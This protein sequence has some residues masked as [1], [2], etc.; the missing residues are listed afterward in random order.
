MSRSEWCA[1][2]WSSRAANRSFLV[3]ESRCP[4]PR[5]TP[6]IREEE[7]RYEYEVPSESL[8]TH[9]ASASHVPLATHFF[10]RHSDLYRIAAAFRSTVGIVMNH[11]HGHPRAEPTDEAFVWRSSSHAR[12]SKKGHTACLQDP[13]N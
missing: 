10:S 4:Q 6:N 1:E 11:G 2:A 9:F 5:A 7:A 13:P 3:A 8:S 12:E